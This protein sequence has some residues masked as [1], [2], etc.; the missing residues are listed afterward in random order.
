LIPHQLEPA[1]CSGAT[2][3]SE[4][5]VGARQRVGADVAPRHTG[6]NGRARS[7]SPR[8]DGIGHGIPRAIETRNDA[9]VLAQNT[10]G[11]VCPCTALGAQDRAV[12][13]HRIERSAL[14]GA[15]RRIVRCVPVG[16][17]LVT[18]PSVLAATEILIAS[19]ATELVEARAR[20]GISIL[21]RPLSTEPK[22][23]RQEQHTFQPLR[24]DDRRC[25]KFV[26]RRIE[27]ECYSVRT[28]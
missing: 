14:D 24:L 10:T 21:Y 20:A 8:A 18:L 9:T 27:A 28:F 22:E 26:C 19:L 13:A 7:H 17:G 23:T 3:Q 11:G 25:P 16:A 2:P 5:V 1:P 4:A 15:E 6:T 12:E